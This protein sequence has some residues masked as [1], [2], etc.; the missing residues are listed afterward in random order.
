MSDTNVP[1]MKKHVKSYILVFAALL[2]LTI[3]TVTVSSLHLGIAVAVTIALII[4]AMKGSLVA[5]FFMH[6]I[7]EKKVVF[8]ALILTLVFLLALL[9]LPLTEYY[10]RIGH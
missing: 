7:S 1:E 6:L 5:S 8:L 9:F 3:I 10:D 2:V 4:A